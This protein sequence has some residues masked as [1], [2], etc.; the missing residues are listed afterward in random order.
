MDRFLT[1]Q[2]TRSNSIPKEMPENSRANRAKMAG[3][4]PSSPRRRSPS[5]RAARIQ[6][7]DIERIAAEVAKLI[8]P[9]IALTVEQA[10]TKALHDVRQE[11]DEHSRAIEET[12]Q[13]LGTVEDEMSAV[14]ARIKALEALTR[15]QAEK[16]DDLEN[17][18]RRNN[19]RIVGLPES[20]PQQALTELCQRKIPSL[21]G[22]TRNCIVE[23]AHRLGTQ[24][25][26]QKVPRQTIVKYL[27]YPDKAEILTNFKSKK[28]LTFEGHNLLLFADYS[29]EV[30][31]KRKL[32]SPICT[33]LFE[34]NVRFS[35]AYPAILRFASKE[36]RQLIFK[37]PEEAKNYWDTLTEEDRQNLGQAN[38]GPRPPTQRK[39]QGGF[40]QRKGRGR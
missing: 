40:N 34:K 33:S 17:R 29:M 39:D 22:I 4:E 7:I 28:R 18:S 35:L 5:P 30:T 38:G 26:D 23:R 25:P 8:Q 37:D 32:F 15:E 11:L 19:L 14:L 3:S 12:E 6:D 20:Y 27:Q 1:R 31:R 24:H 2:R 13:R 36:G 16:L 21:L 9:T 10:L